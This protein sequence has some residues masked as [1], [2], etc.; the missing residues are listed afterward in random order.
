MI[1]SFKSFVSIARIRCISSAMP[2]VQSSR[3]RF[4]SARKMLSIRVFKLLIFDS[5]SVL[6]DTSAYS[7]STTYLPNGLALLIIWMN[8][9]WQSYWVGKKDGS[10]ERRLVL[11]WKHFIYVNA[12]RPD[13]L[14]VTIN[15]IQE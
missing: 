11:W 5:V 4:L 15:C 13:E 12:D 3:V 7:K 6:T 10:E 9:H 1:H 14:P 2:S 8:L